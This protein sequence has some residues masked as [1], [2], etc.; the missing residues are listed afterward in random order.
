MYSGKINTAYTSYVG[1]AATVAGAPGGVGSSFDGIGAV[2]CAGL[3]G[4]GV[5]PSMM[6]QI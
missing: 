5:R 3:G 2:C 1:V 6:S 4:R